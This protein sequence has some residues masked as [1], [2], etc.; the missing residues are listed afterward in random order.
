MGEKSGEGPSQCRANFIF[1]AAAEHGCREG[2]RTINRYLLVFDFEAAFDLEAL[3]RK[4]KM[5]D[6][7][8]PVF[9]EIVY[10]VA[11]ILPDHFG[12]SL[13]AFRGFLF[14]VLVGNGE[15][16]GRHFISSFGVKGVGLRGK[17]TGTLFGQHVIPRIKD[18]RRKMSVENE[19]DPDA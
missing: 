14:A 19:P 11:I 5:Q 16:Q 17:L 8:H 13:Y 4:A 12:V 3:R 2:Q 7:F 1:D 10:L 18:R 6:V 15:S 9:L